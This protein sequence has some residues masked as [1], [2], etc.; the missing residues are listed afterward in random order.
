MYDCFK[1]ELGPDQARGAMVELGL[2]TLRD[3]NVV[4]PHCLDDR[5]KARFLHGKCQRITG[6]ET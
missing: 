6:V 5:D 1:F 2:A 4:L 3:T